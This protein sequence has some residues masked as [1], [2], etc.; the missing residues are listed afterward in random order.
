MSDEPGVAA[1]PTDG[2]PLTGYA[3]TTRS[4]D[5][6][7]GLRAF[8]AIQ[9]QIAAVDF[10]ATTAAARA[11]R[12]ATAIQ[13]EDVAVARDAIVKN[14]AQSINFSR[15]VTTHKFCTEATSL[16]YAEDAQ[17]R[18]AH[19][20]SEAVNVSALRDSIASSAALAA[21]YAASSTLVESLKQWA[22][23]QRRVAEIFTFKLPRIDFGRWVEVV[24]NWIPRNLQGIQDLEAVATIALDEGL[25]LSWI[26][27]TEIVV[28]IIEADTPEARLEILAQHQDEILDDC[29]AALRPATHEVALQCQSAIEALRVG[30]PGPAQSHAS[31]IIDSIVR[32]F[33]GKHGPV[34]ATERAQE[35]FADQ[36][37]GVAAENLTLR[38]LFRA[39]VTWRPSSGYALPNHYAR[40]PTVHAVGHVGIFSPSFALIAVML[41]TSLAVQYGPATNRADLAPSS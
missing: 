13:L 22:D 6:F 38:P 2:A 18:W 4:D 19:S 12:Q 11:I 9:H 34:R 21:S 35:D 30:I 10:T 24:D 25:P 31:N 33:L 40:H 16:K 26:P 28:D 23:D 29:E 27:R 37:L 1:D 14:F 41:A 20:L 36:P 3:P 32:A 5:L 15:L 17:Q 8:S 39:F 7:S